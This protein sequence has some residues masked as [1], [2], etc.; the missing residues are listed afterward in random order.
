MTTFD[1]KITGK[2]KADLV[3]NLT[4]WSENRSA[5]QAERWHDEILIAI[6]SL[7]AMPA[8]YPIVQGATFGRDVRSLLFGLGPRTTHRIYFAIENQSVIVFRIRHTAQTPL[9]DPEEL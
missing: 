7:S 6:R 8:R 3:A 1:I 4:W 2:A 5:S 9:I